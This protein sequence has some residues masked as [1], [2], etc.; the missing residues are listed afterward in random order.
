MYYVMFSALKLRTLP[1]LFLLAFWI[2][3]HKKALN[4]YIHDFTNEIPK[5]LKVHI[6]LYV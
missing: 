6:F 4:Y 3:R 2:Y 1:C 5:V